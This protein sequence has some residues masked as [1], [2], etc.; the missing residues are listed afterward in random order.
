QGG[1]GG[2]RTAAGGASPFRNGG[3]GRPRTRRSREVTREG[4]RSG[5]GVLLS[6]GGG[7]T[8]AETFGEHVVVTETLISK[9]GSRSRSL[10]AGEVVEGSSHEARI[11]GEAVGLF[12]IRAANP[13]K[14]TPC[15]SPKT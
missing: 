8:A 5:S 11:I 15:S 1:D 7:R 13:D 2:G 12:R 9:S 10:V 6:R 3:R 14:K 4:R